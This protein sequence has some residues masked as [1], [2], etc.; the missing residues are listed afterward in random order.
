MS[1]KKTNS[2]H[3]TTNSKLERNARNRSCTSTPGNFNRTTKSPNCRSLWMRG[4][5]NQASIT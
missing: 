4:S 5:A 1:P 2:R 3:D